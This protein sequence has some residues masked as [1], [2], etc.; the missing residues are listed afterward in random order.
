MRRAFTLI[1]IMIVVMIIGILLAVA[2]PAWVRSRDVTRRNACLENMKKIEE[3][4]DIYAMENRLSSG[5]SVTAVQIAPQ[6]IKGI[7]P[8]CPGAGNYT[9]NVIGTHPECSEHGVLP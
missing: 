4:K 1:E 5:D 8:V 6:F 7:F 2:V 9:V 3:A